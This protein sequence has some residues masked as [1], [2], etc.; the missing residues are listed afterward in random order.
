MQRQFSSK[1][2]LLRKRIKQNKKENLFKKAEDSE[3]TDRKVK[4]D[5]VK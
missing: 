1:M 3:D 5:S 4:E 2:R